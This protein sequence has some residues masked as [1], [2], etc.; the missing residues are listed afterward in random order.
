MPHPDHI[1]IDVYNQ[2]A[3]IRGP[4]TREEK[5]ALDDVISRKTDFLKKWCDIYRKLSRTRS[6]TKKRALEKQLREV[7][8][9][10]EMIQFFEIK[11]DT[12][13]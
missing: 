6:K 12:E 7:R 13:R 10:L 3:A 2:T 9:I 11:P 5:A 1:E 8:N 4:Q